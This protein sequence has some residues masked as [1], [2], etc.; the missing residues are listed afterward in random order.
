[1]HEKPVASNPNA[2]DIDELF[3]NEIIKVKSD[4]SLSQS[5]LS[6]LFLFLETVCRKLFPLLPNSIKEKSKEDIINWLLPRLNGED[7][8]GGIFP[9][10]VNALI[11]F[12][13]VDEDKYKNQISTIKRSID[14]LV[15]KRYSILST[16][17]FTGMGYWMDGVG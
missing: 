13:I 8:L 4:K 9:A 11:A 6:F 10:M 14:N 3:T 2:I 1:M 12:K 16:L 7:G 15:K 17:C 5:F